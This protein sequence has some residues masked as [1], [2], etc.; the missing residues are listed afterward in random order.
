VYSARHNRQPIND[1]NEGSNIYS[2]TL[3]Y[4]VYS[5]D[6]IQSSGFSVSSN[7][8]VTASAIQSGGFSVQSAVANTYTEVTIPASGG[9]SVS[10]DGH[11][12]AF[13]NYI[14]KTVR[15]YKDGVQ[16]GSTITS[17]EVYFG[18]FVSLNRDGSVL[19]VGGPFG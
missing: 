9:T 18:A 17:S 10:Y 4:P 12:T 1:V 11:W 6:A 13:G 16:F 15:I 2:I 8:L 14:S 19:A 5:Q 3:P 7:G